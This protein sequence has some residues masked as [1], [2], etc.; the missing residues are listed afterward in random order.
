[1]VINVESYVRPLHLYMENYKTAE[2]NYRN[3]K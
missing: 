1:M 2:R 3:L